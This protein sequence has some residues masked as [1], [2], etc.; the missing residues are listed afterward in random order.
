MNSIQ[1]LSRALEPKLVEIKL[2]IRH[3][4]NENKVF[5]LLEGDTDIKLFRNIFSH[6]YTDTIEVKGKDKVIEGLN[7]LI[8][9]G[10][11]N[12]IGIAD[13]DFDNLEEIAY[14]NNLFITD[15]HDMEIQ[16]IETE[17]FYSTIN[18]YSN[19]ECYAFLSENLKENIYDIAIKIGYIRWYSHK[20]NGL[21]NFK[22]IKLNNLVSY[23]DCQVSFDF[24]KLIELL[25]EQIDYDINIQDEIDSLKLISI[26]SLQI[27][28]G[29]DMTLLMAQYFS[30][31]NINKDK[32][33][34]SLRLSYTFSYFKTTNLFNNLNIWADS[35][36]YQVFKEN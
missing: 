24:D 5:I 11:K 33:E 27:C 7:N 28:N 16:M 25:I 32:I 10:Y 3:P 30:R 12:I 36:Y 26:D 13:A 21:F 8:E 35:N 22:R 6:N 18:E 23:L 20:N 1:A 14:N 31:G 19:G 17:A 15:Y 2:S 34:E 9:D 29:H 4:Q